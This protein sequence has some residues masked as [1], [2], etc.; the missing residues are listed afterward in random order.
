[1]FVD[2]ARHPHKQSRLS[3]FPRGFVSAT[4]AVCFARSD[5]TAVRCD[6]RQIGK[7]ADFNLQLCLRVKCG[8]LLLLFSQVTA[9]I[10][11]HAV[12][13]PRADFDLRET[14]QHHCRA[15]QR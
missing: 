9:D 5:A 13:V 3:F 6:D 14:L 4:A 7:I 11:R 10:A 1:M 15:Y 12:D 8:S 2:F